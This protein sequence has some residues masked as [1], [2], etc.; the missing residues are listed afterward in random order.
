MRLSS[1]RQ[2]GVLLVAATI[3]SSADAQSIWGICGP[4]A[5]VTNQAGPPGGPCAY[6]TGPNLSVIPYAVAFGC[7][8]PGAFPPP[9]AALFPAGDV[10]VDR[11]TDIVYATD[12]ILVASYS[13]AGAPLASFPNPLGGL[14]TGL[15]WSAPNPIGPALLWITNGFFCCA[16]VPPVA[17]CPG[18]P[19][20]VVPPF[21]VM[22]PPGAVA[23][24]VDFDPVSLTLFFA[25]SSG[26][27]SNQL[28]GGA[29]GPYGAFMP[30]GLPCNM[31]PLTGL[32]MDT[33]SCKTM[34]ITNGT[35]V[36]RIDFA[37]FVAPPTFYAPFMC[38]PWTGAAPT[39]G[40]GFDA[41]P[42]RFGTGSDPAGS[43]PTIGTIGEAISPN[44]G[45]GLTLGGATPGGAAYL[46]ISPMSA[47]PVV[48]VGFGA[49]IH[50]FP[51][52]SIVGPFPIPAT[53]GFSAVTGLPGGLGCSNAVAY[54]EWLVVKPGGA[55]LE[56]SPGLHIR[57][58]NP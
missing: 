53:G 9:V 34:Y 2:L 29:P 24:D 44:P 20:F 31:G 32:A 17:G 46:L 58:A 13:K 6:P 30:M 55:G 50:V 23:T 26:L 42:V 48:P 21:P 36:A 16:V 37:G 56:T 57:P 45:F 28:I 3:A 43:I 51:I 38:W 1:I 25:H 5:N 39:A 41:T 47:C 18:V 33:S 52:S 10:T 11:I 22:S 8:L 19:P 12:G 7:P 27:V 35:N 49:F 54:L 15:G 40:L 14:I 4:P